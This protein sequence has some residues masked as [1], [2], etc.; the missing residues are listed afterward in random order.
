MGAS[1]VNKRQQCHDFCTVASQDSAADPIRCTRIL[2]VHLPSA[3]EVLS[4]TIFPLLQSSEVAG[5]SWSRQTK[6]TRGA[7]VNQPTIE[8][9][10]S[11]IWLVGCRRISRAKRAGLP[12]LLPAGADYRNGQDRRSGTLRGFQRQESPPGGNQAVVARL[13]ERAER[14]RQGAFGRGSDQG[15]RDGWLGSGGG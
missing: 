5:H 2:T 8:E 13:P 6:H 7:A 10:V 3:M 9:A 12:V 14:G 15:C 11:G 4:E 1:N